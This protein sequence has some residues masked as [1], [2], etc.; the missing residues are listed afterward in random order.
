MEQEDRAK[1]VS[2]F[3]GG[4]TGTTNNYV[5]AWFLGFSQN[6]VT[7]VWTGFDENQ[8]LGWGETGAK[9][10]LPPWTEFMRAGVKKYG[11]SDFRVPMGI[12][13]VYIDKDSGKPIGAGREGAFLESF[14]EGTEPGAQSE[15]NEDL[16][17][18]DNNGPILEE[19]D[20]YLNQ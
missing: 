17:D 4:K 10:A 19:D 2:P 16:D 15:D 7:G 3:L 14:V 12:V 6:L 11:E 8:T 13:N 1:S 20:Y 5:D 9:S 18:E